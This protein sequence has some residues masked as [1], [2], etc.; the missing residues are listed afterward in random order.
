MS[1]S[2]FLSRSDVERD[3]KYVVDMYTN[4][5]RQ[6]SLVT[7]LVVVVTDPAIPIFS[8][9]LPR[10]G[11]WP[12]FVRNICYFVGRFGVSKEEPTHYVEIAIREAFKAWRTL[13]SSDDFVEEASYLYQMGDPFFARS[14]V[15]KGGFVVS[16][17]GRSSKQNYEFARDMLAVCQQT[18]F[19]N[20]NHSMLLGND[21]V[22]QESPFPSDIDLVIYQGAGAA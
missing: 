17:A 10:D 16:C 13:C 14:I 18:A 6:I 19:V 11:L 2:T 20:K 7:E 3:F 5:N 12:Y 21:H 8:P 22:I 1:G 4:A 15:G 9:G